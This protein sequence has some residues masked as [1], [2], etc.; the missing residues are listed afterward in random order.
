MLGA[1]VISQRLSL[2]LFSL[3]IGLGEQTKKD[4]PLG[5]VMQCVCDNQEWNFLADSLSS[6]LSVETE[7]SSL[8]VKTSEEM[9]H[10]GTETQHWGQHSETALLMQIIPFG[11]LLV[12]LQTCML[13]TFRALREIMLNRNA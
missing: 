6:S 12:N 11:K 10:N 3:S 4:H 7:E 2:C 1:L 5:L 8:E 9:D 13:E